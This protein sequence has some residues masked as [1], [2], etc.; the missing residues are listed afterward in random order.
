M[1]ARAETAEAER[2]AYVRLYAKEKEWRSEA[3]VALASL[4]FS[5]EM[6]PAELEAERKRHT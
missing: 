4:K 6:T 2:D 5:S 1:A 3:E